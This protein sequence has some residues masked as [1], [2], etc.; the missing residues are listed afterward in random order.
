MISEIEVRL[1]NIDEKD[2]IAKLTAL[3]AKFVGNWLQKRYVYD[4]K[5]AIKNKW[6]RLRTNG[7]ETTLA[8]KHYQSSEIGGTKELE[9]TVDDFTKT[10]LI[11]QELGYQARSVQENRRIRYILDDVEIDI[12]TWPHLKPYVE[13]EARN[14]DDI[15][16]TMNKLQLDFAKTTT[17]D[18]QDIYLSQGF[19]EQDLNILKF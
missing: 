1:L 14:V 19:S 12:D 2:L 7:E 8:I 13:F 17:M 10:D 5:P 11:L 18:A 15:K 6:I 4:F 9:I 3:N 16:K